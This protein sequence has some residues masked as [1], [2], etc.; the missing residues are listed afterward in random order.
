[1]ISSLKLQN[2]RGIKQGEID[3]EPLT[4]LLGPNNSG[5]TTILEALFL[6]PN[7]LRPTSYM[8]P[9]ITFQGLNYRS[10]PAVYILHSLHETLRSTGYAFLF[11]NYIAEKAEIECTVDDLKYIITFFRNK[12]PIYIY[13]NKAK[14]TQ[15]IHLPQGTKR[16]FGEIHELQSTSFRCVDY[17]LFM[18]DIILMNPQLIKAGY[19]YLEDNW[20]SI[21]NLGICK[22]VA[23]EASIFSSDKYIDIT[24]EP[25]LAKHNAINALFKDGRRIRLGDLGEGIQRYLIMKILFS[26]K[27]T[28]VL[29][30][31]DI[32]AHLNPRIL[33]AIGNWF[34]E[35][36][37]K[38][39]QIVITSHSIEAIRT[40][41]KLNE[42]KTGIYLVNLD[43]D[44]NLNF[45][46]FTYQELEDQIDAGID[47]RL[48]EKFLL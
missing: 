8:F 36:I 25:F 20:A 12:G 30:W 41:A 45:K 44:H 24:I 23:E 4:I 17:S 28:Q 15:P 26:I 19:N 13:S 47:I 31:D 5:K 6:A 46:K 48:A 32:E 34:S 10:A 9:P 14:S 21:F 33:V 1:M 37:E 39:K 11:H 22:K 2:F 18:K 35:I 43:S 3:L 7:P 40:I 27:D 38:G 16:S 42:E 29:L